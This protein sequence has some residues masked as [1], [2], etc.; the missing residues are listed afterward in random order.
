MNWFC[1]MILVTCGMTDFL[2]CSLKDC[3]FLENKK[4]FFLN[5]SFQCKNF[6]HVN[7]NYQEVRLINKR[8]NFFA[9]WYVEICFLSPTDSNNE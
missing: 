5:V 1:Q 3:L 6:Y 9:N 4:K 2:S 7:V 8:E